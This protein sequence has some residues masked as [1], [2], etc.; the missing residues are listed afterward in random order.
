MSYSYSTEKDGRKLFS[1]ARKTAQCIAKALIATRLPHLVEEAEM[2]AFLPTAVAQFP[3]L[4]FQI[5]HCALPLS[6][7]FALQFVCSE[8]RSKAPS[9]GVC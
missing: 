8:S 1:Y 4:C 2:A 9:T 5:F 6:F 7:E 3:D